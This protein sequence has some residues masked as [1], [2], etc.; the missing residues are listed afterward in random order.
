MFADKI[1]K[2]SK[3][4]REMVRRRKKDQL[5]PEQA[6]CILLAL[7]AAFGMYKMT[8]SLVGAG[9]GFGVVFGAYIVIM[10]L[11]NQKREERL[12]RSGIAET[13]KMEGRQFEEYLGICSKHMG[14]VSK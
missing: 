7:G 11:I 6:L 4:S 13:D 8:N 12:K 3:R 5:E 1:I 2:M 14:I 10:I 9:V